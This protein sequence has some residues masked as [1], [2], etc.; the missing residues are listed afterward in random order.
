MPLIRPPP[1]RRQILHLPPS[2]RSTLYQHSTRQFHASSPQKSSTLLDLPHELLLSLHNISGAWALTI[3][4][5]AITIR[6]CLLTVQIPA[7]TALQRRIQTLP[8]ITAFRSLQTKSFITTVREGGRAVDVKAY[9]RGQLTLRKTAIEK[10]WG[11][12]KAYTYLSYLQIPIFLSMAECMRSMLG[13]ERGLLG[14]VISS[15]KSLDEDS[16]VGEVLEGIE[17]P[18]FHPEW[19]E[20]S[21]ATEGML[22]FTDLT[23]ADPTITLPFVVSGLIVANIVLSGGKINAADQKPWQR[24][25]KRGLIGMGLCIGPLTLNVPAGI[26]YYWACSSA[27]GL[28][29]NLWI[30]RVWPIKKPVMACKRPLGEDGKF[31]FGS[32][33]RETWGRFGQ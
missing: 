6:A 8:F 14:A 20:P 22:W 32:T 15:V 4:L 30:D 13:M 24:G 1:F 18:V 25:L 23:I 21:M 5:A 31:G 16:N 3:P 2:V 19:I 9:Q 28:A 33:P 26:L 10:I 11:T 29:A 7:R 27:A 17:K 12:G